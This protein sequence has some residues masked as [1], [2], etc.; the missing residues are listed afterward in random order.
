[1]D[2]SVQQNVC[3][4]SVDGTVGR[5]QTVVGQLISVPPCTWPMLAVEAANSRYCGHGVGFGPFS[6]WRGAFIEFYSI[7]KAGWDGS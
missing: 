1:M 7:E 3:T 6:A 2:A 5:R 4:F